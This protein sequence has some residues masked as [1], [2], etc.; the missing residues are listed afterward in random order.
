MTE[1]EFWD[2]IIGT[3]CNPLECLFRILSARGFLL[4]LDESGITVSDNSHKDDREYLNKIL[5]ECKVGQVIENKVQLVEPKYIHK[6]IHHFSNESN[7]KE[8]MC[9]QNRGWRYFKNIEYAKKV[10]VQCLE[11]YVARYIKAISACG[12]DTISCCDGN[13]LNGSKHIL[14]CMNDSG[15]RKYHSI[16]INEFQNRF[17]HLKWDDNKS[18][19]QFTKES[20]FDC[21]YELNQLAEFL[22]CN[23]LIF[24]EIREESINRIPNSYIRE[25]EDDEIASLFEQYVKEGLKESKLMD[26]EGCY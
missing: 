19:I 13:H 14:V 9:F 2:K 18:M 21:Y 1:K 11:T 15:S 8:G 12:I 7:I 23:R 24:R 5:M 4:D 22:Y 26:E 10:P 25:K 16:L 6:L 20:Q 17:P 3:D